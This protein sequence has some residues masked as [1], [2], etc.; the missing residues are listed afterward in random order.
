MKKEVTQ[1]IIGAMLDTI[2]YIRDAEKNADALYSADTIRNN[3]NE[4]FAGLAFALGAMT[5]KEYHWSNGSDGD[6]WA[7][8]IQESGKKDKYIYRKGMA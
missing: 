8:V 5:G 2:G 3:M 4:Y 6:V 1:T 7:L